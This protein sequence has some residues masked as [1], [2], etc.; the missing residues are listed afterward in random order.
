MNL[1]SLNNWRESERKKYSTK[2]PLKRRAIRNFLNK[3]LELIP[4]HV[5]TILDAGC[6]EGV[7]CNHVN[8]N[9]KASRFLG[10]DLSIEALKA[11]R[12]WNPNTDFI[13]AS[14]YSFPL[15]DKSVDS[16][17]CL[18]VMEHLEKPEKALVELKRVTRNSLIISVP[19][20]ILFRLAS[21]ASLKNLTRL[22]ED[23]DHIQSY[24]KGSFQSLLRREF[25]KSKVH[26]KK[27]FPWLIAS[28]QNLT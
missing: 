19:N 15:K 23:P 25:P 7:V 16:S 24:A 14:V 26:I 9:R 10:T 5:E 2:N 22:G 18:E 20:S 6:G 13:R 21:I 1:A 12:S 11:A 27:S 8:R 17:L 4:E 3:I 28:V